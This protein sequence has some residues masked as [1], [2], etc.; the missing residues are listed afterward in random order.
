VSKKL[1]AQLG[2]YTKSIFLNVTSIF[3]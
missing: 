2:L 3:E 1:N